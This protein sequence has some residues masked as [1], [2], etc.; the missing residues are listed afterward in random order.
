MET[1]G[2]VMAEG[3]NNAAHLVWIANIKSFVRHE[4]FHMGQVVGNAGRTLHGKP[5]FNHQRFVFPGVIEVIKQFLFQS[6][7]ICS[8]VVNHGAQRGT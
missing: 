8:R 6:L 3:P 1:H 5:L 4:R 2:I 7:R